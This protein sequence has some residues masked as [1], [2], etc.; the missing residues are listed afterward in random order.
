MVLLGLS[1]TG[2]EVID[3]LYFIG[4]QLSKRIVEE[5]D[6]RY[7]RYPENFMFSNDVAYFCLLLASW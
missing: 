4:N 6:F 3:L 7:L 1:L 2:L 5:K